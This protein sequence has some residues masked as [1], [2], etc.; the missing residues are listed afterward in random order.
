M[1]RPFKHFDLPAQHLSVV[2]AHY[3]PSKARNDGE[4]VRR[5][6]RPAGALVLEQQL[7]GIQIAAD[8]LGRLEGHPDTNFASRMIAVAGL[9][10]AHYTYPKGGVMRRRLLLPDLIGEDGVEP[11]TA[12]DHR[13][14]ARQSLREATV[15]AEGLVFAIG[16]HSIRRERMGVGRHLG[17]TSLHLACADLADYLPDT[18]RAISAVARDY[19]MNLLDEARG[20]AYE[21]GTPPSL[22]QLDDPNSDTTVY[23][24]R[25]APNAAFQAFEQARAT[26]GMA[27]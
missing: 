27:A 16:N 1:P 19:S 6:A 20:M 4:I 26:Y 25:L 2:D 17:E 7:H 8:V 12:A 14:A 24:N 5:T 13:A 3:V 9:N 10:S 21:I 15:A 22:A 11:P 18:E 23:I